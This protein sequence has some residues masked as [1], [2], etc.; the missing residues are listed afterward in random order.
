[1]DCVPEKLEGKGHVDVIFDELRLLPGT[2]DLTVALTD[3]SSLHAYDV[4]T[5]ILRFDVERGIYHEDA[6]VV[7]L[8]G[9]WE[10][11]DHLP[12]A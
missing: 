10:I 5:D 4:R 9:R 1:V 12:G 7:A 8:G 6:G 2:Y 3:H 11:D